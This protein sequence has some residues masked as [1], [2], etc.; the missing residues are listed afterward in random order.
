VHEESAGKK[1][2]KDDEDQRQPPSASRKRC[3]G[4]KLPQSP[5]DIFRTRISE[6]VPFK[7]LWSQATASE[8][9]GK[10]CLQISQPYKLST[11][12]VLSIC[13]LLTPSTVVLPSTR[14]WRKGQKHSVCARPKLKGLQPYLSPSICLCQINNSGHCR[15]TI[16]TARSLSELKAVK[17]PLRQASVIYR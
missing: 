11:P 10:S 13:V 3:L 17:S 6:E 16:S 1:T 15:K 7:T 8:P 9:Q 2:S 4:R 14:T 12:E 5:F